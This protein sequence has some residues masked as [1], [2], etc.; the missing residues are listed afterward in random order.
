MTRI[1][2]ISDTHGYIHPQVETLFAN[3]EHI[4]H[5]GDVGGIKVIERLEKIAP[6]TIVKGNYDNEP[7]IQD[8]LLKDPG[9]A[10]IF[11]VQFFLTHRMITISWDQHKHLIANLM[12][13]KGFAPQVMVFGHTHFAVCE[14]IRD[15][16]FINPGYCGPDEIEGPRT[17]G[18]IK[19]EVESIEGKILKLD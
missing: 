18:I 8:R 16:L 1:G 10:V 7:D 11:G 19:I 17:L 4:V 15:I 12:A 14:R 9:A 2:V 3:V 6:L 13:D 5:A